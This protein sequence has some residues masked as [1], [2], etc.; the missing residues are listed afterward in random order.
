MKWGPPSEVVERMAKFVLLS[1]SGCAEWVGSR[2]R[3]GYGKFRL[4]GGARLA[5]RVSYVAWRGFIPG[6]YQL[7]HLCRN[8]RCVNPFHLEAV[9]QVEN[10]RRG[11]V[12]TTTARLNEAKRRCPSG[13]EYAGENLVVARGQR[14]CRTC[15]AMQ[16]AASKARRKLH[17]RAVSP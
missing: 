16:S 3:N 17:A 15:K 14:I 6:G 1:P 4:A 10:I 8:R 7:D 12:G 9:T 13:H 11:E 5:H 2:V